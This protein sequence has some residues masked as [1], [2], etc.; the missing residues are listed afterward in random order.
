MDGKLLTDKTKD[1]L[2]EFIYQ[3]AKDRLPK[4][5]RLFG[6]LKVGIRF[7]INYLNDKGDKVIPDE[8]DIYINESI[9]K[10]NEGQF[11]AAVAAIANAENKLINLPNMD[12][13]QEYGVWYANSYALVLNIKALI[14]KTKKTDRS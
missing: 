11:D 9:V 1:I 10:F 7:L 13:T 3:K 6:I 14:E 2:V 4:W 5:V 8:I 12:E